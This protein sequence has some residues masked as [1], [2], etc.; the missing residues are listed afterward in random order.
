MPSVTAAL[1]RAAEAGH[2]HVLVT[3]NELQAAFATRPS[4]SGDVLRETFDVFE[5][6]VCL[7]SPD[8]A[9]KVANA[10]GERLYDSR[11]GPELQATAKDAVSRER[12]RR[13]HGAAGRTRVRRARVPADRPRRRGLRPRRDRRTR[14]RDRPPA[15]GEAGVDRHAGRG[16]RA[17]GQQPGRIR[18]R[19]HRGADRQHAPHRRQAARA[20]RGRRGALGAFEPAVRGQRHPAGIEGGDGAHS[21]HRPRPGIVFARRRRRQR[22]AEREHGGRIGADHAA[23]RDQVPR[24]RRARPAR[25][26][27][28][29]RQRAAPGA[30]VPEPDLER[31]SGDGR[32]RSQAQP[33][34]RAQLRR[35]RPRGRR[36][37]RQRPR[38]PDRGHA[39]HLRVVLHDQTARHGHGAGAA[40]LARHRARPGRRHH[41]GDTARRKA[42]RSASASRRRSRERPP[43]PSRCPR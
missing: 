32:S 16:R 25:E 3:P 22:A 34:A 29:A 4:S 41:G 43:L 12:D 37:D 35:S 42:R 40:D 18:A 11:L 21:A 31:R 24:A 5:D 23:Q 19:E 15:G 9:L 38:H 39:A 33:A 28:R 7:I 30:G 20:P 10:M 17:R 2:T 1:V 36:G 14:A 26:A 8:G 6:A 13:S 27:A